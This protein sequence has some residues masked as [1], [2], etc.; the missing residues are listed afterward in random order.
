VQ[1]EAFHIIKSGGVAVHLGVTEGSK[2]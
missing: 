1:K 2:G